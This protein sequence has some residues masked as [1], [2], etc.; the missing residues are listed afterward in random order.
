MDKY[1]LA[2]AEPS[3]KYPEGRTGT[4]AGYSSHKAVKQPPCGLCRLAFNAAVNARSSRYTETRR[5][6]S[7]KTREQRAFSAI[8]RNY[9]LTRDQY[10]SISEAQNWRCAICDTEKV[11]SKAD[12]LHVDHDH[13]C[14]SG[15]RSCGK[16]V[17]GLLCARCNA[18]LGAFSDDPDRLLAA[19]AYLLQRR[20][21]LME[22]KIGDLD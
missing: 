2:C 9:N 19:A 8:E 12:K 11:G 17:R 10:V 16:C 14:C 22:V 1:T 7:E 4:E 15:A 3:K 5:I 21:V 6:W 20:D 13:S 18:G